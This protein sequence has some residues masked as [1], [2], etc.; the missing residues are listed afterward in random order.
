MI[1]EYFAVASEVATMAFFR[2][3]GLPMPDFRVVGLND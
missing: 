3:F 1:P 2:S